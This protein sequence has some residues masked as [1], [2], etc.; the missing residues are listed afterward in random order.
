MKHK[1]KILSTKKITHN[2]NSYKVENPGNN[3]KDFSVY[4]LSVRT[5]PMIEAVQTMFENAGSAP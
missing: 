5:I 2:I 3:I 1:V 4:F